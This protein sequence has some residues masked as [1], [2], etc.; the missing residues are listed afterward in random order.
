MWQRA[1]EECGGGG[2][3]RRRANLLSAR[4]KRAIGAARL[5]A[6]SSL[7]SV[8]RATGAE[9]GSADHR[10][11]RA[12]T[13]CGSVL[14]SGARGMRTMAR[15]ARARPASAAASARA[16]CYHHQRHHAHATT[17]TTRGAVVVP[18]AATSPR[19]RGVGASAHH[20]HRDVAIAAAASDGSQ[21]TTS[22]RC[23]GARS[24]PSSRES[25]PSHLDRHN[26]SDAK[27]QHLIL[28]THLPSFLA[29]LADPSSSPAARR[30]HDGSRRRPRPPPPRP[31]RRRRR[32]PRRRRRRRRPPRDV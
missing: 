17:T 28:M 15:V 25:I 7:H 27:T 16:R 5:S 20:A 1:R 4:T 30:V 13:F 2:A 31:R 11:S 9:H 22:R 14:A 10:A 24:R 8:A 29:T 6:V 19:P 18:G 26:P 21:D 32:R 3:N 12:M 23:A